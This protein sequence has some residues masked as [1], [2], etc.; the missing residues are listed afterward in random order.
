[1]GPAKLELMQ[2]LSEVVRYED[3][4][5]PLYIRTG[6]LSA[7]PGMSAPCHWHDDI[8]WICVLKGRMCYHI[9]GERLVLE[10]R[11][12]LMVNTRQ[13]HY[14]YSYERQDCHFICILFHPSL[15]GNNPTLLQRYVTPI[16]D[17]AQLRYLH[18]PSE[19][20]SET[21]GLLLKILRLREEA[22]EGYEL[23]AIA[24]MQTLWSRLIKQK[25]LLPSPDGPRMQDD[26]DTQKEMVAF[27]YQYYP[28]KL[29]LDQIA[30]SGHVSRSKCCRIFKRYLK[31]SP[32][33]FLNTYRLKVSCSLLAHTDKPVTEIALACGFNHLSYFSKNFCGMYGCTPR[34]YREL[35]RKKAEDR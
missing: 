1:M 34:E 19:K 20:A 14:G 11:D 17:N 5:I 24:L 25:I 12:V 6:D 26:L 7:Y 22:S 35:S 29:T 3:A 8:E 31:Q 16:L 27:L 2:D 13:M 4:G 9:N 33:D 28:E 21:A 15:F 23:G 32:I 10:E 30:A 18:L